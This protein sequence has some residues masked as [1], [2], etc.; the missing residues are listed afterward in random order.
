MWNR[1]KAHARY[2]QSSEKFVT[3][4]ELIDQLIG[5]A[6]CECE[7]GSHPLLSDIVTKLQIDAGSGR[8]SINAFC[9]LTD[10]VDRFGSVLINQKYCYI[11]IG[12]DI[13]R[14]LRAAA[15]FYLTLTEMS[16]AFLNMWIKANNDRNAKRAVMEQFDEISYRVNR[17]IW[18]SM[19]DKASCENMGGGSRR[20]IIV[21]D[22]RDSLEDFADDYCANLDDGLALID[23]LVVG[24]IVWVICHEFAH[25]AKV[26]ISKKARGAGLEGLRS[27]ISE[28]LKDRADEI[29]ISDQHYDEYLCDYIAHE[30][31][32]SSRLDEKWKFSALIASQLLCAVIAVS[33]EG[34]DDDGEQTHPSP[35]LRIFMN[36][37][38]YLNMLRDDNVFE[39]NSNMGVIRAIEFARFVT[40]D[41]ASSER[42]FL[43]FIMG[44]DVK[45]QVN[46]IEYLA[47]CDEHFFSGIRD[48]L[49]KMMS[50][51]SS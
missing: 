2:W 48:D 8:S 18:R 37:L 50:A 44:A 34:I 40:G 32:H 49:A 25:I 12:V 19:P 4:D 31:I 7:N 15:R 20:G 39:V 30:Y 43:E 24:G 29:D 13:I 16:H 28:F 38:A 45:L 41:Y 17:C 46:M 10:G 3:E 6:S 9:G 27:S 47:K 1:K 51:S 21:D 14:G 35:L 23:E 33:E 11:S 26:N 42:S 22:I 5:K 36:E